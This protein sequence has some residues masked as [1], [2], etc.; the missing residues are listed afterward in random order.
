MMSTPTT[1]S[2]R[3]R[4]F[5]PAGVVFLLILLASQ[6]PALPSGALGV[7]GSAPFGLS[8]SPTSKGLSR[9]YFEMQV[10]PGQS[11]SD[12]VVISDQGRNAETLLIS[13]AVG[14]TAANSGTAF[15]GAFQPCNTTSCWITG[16]P[17]SVTLSAGQSMTLPFHVNV[18]AGTAPAQ[19]LAGIT[20]KPAEQ[21]GAT[22][23]GGNQRTSVNAIII[24]EITIGVAISTG[25]P[26]QLSSKLVITGVTGTYIGTVPRLLVDVR[27]EGQ[28]YA[29]GVGTATCSEG[30]L[31]KTLPVDVNTI[32]PGQTATVPV[33]AV[34]FRSIADCVV[35]LDYGTPAPA[36]WTGSVK[37][38]VAAPAAPAPVPV[39]KGVYATLPAAKLPKWAL[40]ALIGAGAV[41]LLLLVLL[42][43]SL[44]RRRKGKQGQLASQSGS[45]NRAPNY[46]TPNYDAVARVA[47]T[48]VAPN[49]VPDPEPSLI[50]ASQTVA[51]GAVS[52]ETLAQ[53]PTGD[54]E[55]STTK[56]VKGSSKKKSAKGQ[57]KKNR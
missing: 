21:P 20:A 12:S 57:S 54:V 56:S 45:V 50:R 40:P 5:G 37:I 15:E 16:L 51:S 25:I 35:Q 43:L 36:A 18:P 53:A 11:V 39:A 44:R 4:I 38:P 42:L 33:N 19:Y 29:K 46:Q 34:Q 30:G 10:L 9:P 31:K 28:S 3:A 49:V 26:S 17:S 8:P 23:I 27:N 48:N 14:V 32:L 13:P 1:R 22:N 52:T 7:A 41:V 2:L 47:P 24:H 55:A 6:M